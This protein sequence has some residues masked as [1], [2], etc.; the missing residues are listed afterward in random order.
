MP[1]KNESNL[2]YR[3][4]DQFSWFFFVVLL[5]C[6][7]LLP[8]APLTKLLV[9]GSSLAM[10]VVYTSHRRLM[11]NAPYDSKVIGPFRNWLLAFFGAVAVAATG[12][13]GSPLL[14][15]LI[16]PVMLASLEMGMKEGLMIAGGSYGMMLAG[17]LLSVN[18][19]ANLASGFT[20]VLAQAG[21]L[22]FIA[23]WI[24]YLFEQYAKQ[25]NERELIEQVD[26]EKSEFI[27]LASHHL[28]TPLSSIK[29]YTDFLLSDPEKRLN[30]QQRAIVLR[31]SASIKKLEAVMENLL[32]A[33]SMEKG[34]IK[35]HARL[36]DISRVLRSELT[37]YAAA[38]ET[39]NLKILAEIPDLQGI[40]LSFDENRIR[41]VVNNLLSNALKFTEHG[42]IKVKLSLLPD[43]VVVTIMDTGVGITP[44]EKTMLFQKFK[45]SGSVLG[46][47]DTEGVGLGLY[48]A[49]LIVE[50]HGGKIWVDSEVSRGSAFSFSLPKLK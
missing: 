47:F 1:E 50:A 13:V 39:K 21:L 16:Y 29:G 33:S 24:G 3:F 34:R 48:I 42:Y 28:R 4:I 10:G 32:M 12:G 31:L 36:G 6:G 20:A 18:G 5:I 25:L 37:Q 11:T 44:K 41:E 38:F 43:A 8:P 23:F 7:A 14:V 17:S 9:I 45:R 46:A 2:I 30:D 19:Q 40:E 15:C 27:G 22:L 49:R 26:Q 35:I